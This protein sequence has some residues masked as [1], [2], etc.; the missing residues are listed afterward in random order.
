MGECNTFPSAYTLYRHSE[1]YCTHPMNCYIERPSRR[2]V[3]E[4]FPFPTI[5]LKGFF[6]RIFKTVDC[7]NRSMMLQFLNGFPQQSK[8]TILR[9]LMTESS[10]FLIVWCLT[11]FFCIISDAFQPPEHLFRLFCDFSFFVNIQHNI[12]SKPLADFPAVREEGNLSQ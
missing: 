9:I 8:L 2:N 7:V 1:L 12:L 3:P 4:N 10:V 6:L 5:S 11:L